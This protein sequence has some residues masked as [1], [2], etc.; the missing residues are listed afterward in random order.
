LLDVASAVADI[1]CNSGQYTCINPS[2]T[3]DNL[4][5]TQAGCLAIRDSGVI[6]P[7][8]ITR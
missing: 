3:A 6:D 8:A 2:Y 4:H 7:F 5:E 1:D